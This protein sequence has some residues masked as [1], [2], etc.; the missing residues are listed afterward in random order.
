[1]IFVAAAVILASA[2]QRFIHPVALERL[3]AGLAISTVAT[4]VNGAVGLALIRAGRTHRSATLAADGK[5][6]MTDV[7]TSVGVLVGVLLVALTGWERLDP[8]VAAIVG[9]NILVTGYRLV[10]MATDL[11][12]KWGGVPFTTSAVIRSLPEAGVTTGDTL[13]WCIL[14]YQ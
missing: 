3:G 7:W 11:W 12:S 4:A 10:A 13:C 9:L 8:V 1:M 5:H 2:V 14:Y 6:L